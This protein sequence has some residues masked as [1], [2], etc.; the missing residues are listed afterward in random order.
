M[1]KIS[2]LIFFFI[3]FYYLIFDS[4]PI[5]FINMFVWLCIFLLQWITNFWYLFFIMNRKLWRRK[6]GFF[7]I[8]KKKNIFNKLFC[9][10]LTSEISFRNK[11]NFSFSIFFSIWI[12]SEF[13][14]IVV[15]KNW[16]ITFFLIIKLI[17]SDTKPWKNEYNVICM[18]FI[19]LSLENKLINK[20]LNVKRSFLLEI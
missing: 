18:Y 8:I 17:I 9:T 10:F 11:K 4:L 7:F 1:N 19:I 14:Q 3:F 15:S 20:L 13:V 6:N 16:N 2:Y 12:Q 5:I